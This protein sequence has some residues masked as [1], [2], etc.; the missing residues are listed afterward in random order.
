MDDPLVNYDDGVA[1]ARKLENG[2]KTAAR[3]ASTV[4]IH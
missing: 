2:C 4:I 1:Y 3:T